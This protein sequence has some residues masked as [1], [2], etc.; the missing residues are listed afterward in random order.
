[1]PTEPMAIVVII[2]AGTRLKIAEDDAALVDG[3]LEFGVHVLDQLGIGGDD[4][5]RSVAPVGIRCF[6]AYLVIVPIRIVVLMTTDEQDETREKE[7]KLFHD[8]F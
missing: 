1:M 2:A 3:F 5:E 6:C 8:V 7:I 4:D